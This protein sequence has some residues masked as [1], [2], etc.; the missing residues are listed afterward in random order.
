MVRR[1]VVVGPRNYFSSND[2]I[3]AEEEKPFFRE[4]KFGDH[5]GYKAVRPI[6]MGGEF[7]CDAGENANYPIFEGG[8]FGG[9]AGW[10][11]NYPI[12]KG[13]KFGPLAGKFAIYPIF[14]GGEFG[15][16]AGEESENP[17]FKGGKFG[18]KAG[19]RARN[20][21][22][23]YGEFDAFAGENAEDP[24][25]IGGEFGRSPLRGAK[26][27]KA[28]LPKVKKVVENVKSGYAIIE[29]V[30][31]VHIDSG[32]FF[33]YVT[34]PK[35]V[36]GL[37]KNAFYIDRSKLKE[38]LREVDLDSFKKIEPKTQEEFEEKEFEELY[39]TLSLAMDYLI[40]RVDEEAVPLEEV[41]QKEK[42]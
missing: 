20:P 8:K 27:I 15:H 12:F 23:E 9:W 29:K 24:I 3:G 42:Q 32:D 35:I 28:Y 36:K 2:Y 38:I 25:V 11:S 26:N 16:R 14:K 22:F 13:G 6:F 30:R 40:C 31:K 37:T 1:I 39:E 18:P 33:A 5:A 7:G 34:N 21:I 4:G 17:I 19:Y 10:N 41:L